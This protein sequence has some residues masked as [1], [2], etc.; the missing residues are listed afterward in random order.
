MRVSKILVSLHDVLLR[1][2]RALLPANGAIPSIGEVPLLA[3]D[4]KL[5]NIS[6]SSDFYHDNDGLLL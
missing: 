4:N 6:L 3:W 2:N 1:G 5:F